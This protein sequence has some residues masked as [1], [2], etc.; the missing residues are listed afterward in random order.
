MLMAIESECI[1][2][3][4]FPLARDLVELIFLFL[5]VA[6]WLKHA[7]LHYSS[8]SPGS[9]RHLLAG[10]DVDRATLWEV[11]KDVTSYLSHF[12][13]VVFL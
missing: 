8:I 6:L 11:K 2:I 1:I 10:E 7:G 5:R 13:T 12:K 4:L 3:L 9:Q